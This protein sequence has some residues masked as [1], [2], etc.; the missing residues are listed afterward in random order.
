MG[1]AEVPDIG[2]FLDKL[3]EQEEVEEAQL[4]GFLRRNISFTET[5]QG[6]HL[7]TALGDP[8]SQYI[9]IEF[10]KVYKEIDGRV[11]DKDRYI[12]L[13]GFEPTAENLAEHLSVDTPVTEDKMYEH[14]LDLTEQHFL[15]ERTFIDMEAEE[16]INLYLLTQPSIATDYIRYKILPEW[17][18]EA[19]KYGQ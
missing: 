1:E 5:N 17:A 19:E 10:Y 7:E 14:I 18:E 11:R 15:R 16:S 8:V 4:D 12:D 6:E 3:E 2:D 13:W 9:A